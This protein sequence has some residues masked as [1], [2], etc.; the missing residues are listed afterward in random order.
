MKAKILVIDDEESLRFTFGRFLESAVYEVE[1]AKDYQEASA[2]LAE[3]DFDLVFAD[4]ILGGKTGIDILREVKARNPVCTVVMITGYPELETA[5]DALR[6]GAFDYIP[7]PVQKEML[8]RVAAQA[9]KH[10]QVVD[11]KERY[12]SNLEAISRACMTQSLRWMSRWWSWRSMRRP[13]AS[14]VCPATLWGGLSVPFRKDATG[15][16]SKRWQ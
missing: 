6:L 2:V 3:K 4:I 16:V 8:L 5:S 9:L 14:M 15:N 1:T 13:G 10:K 7:K 12:R 11:E